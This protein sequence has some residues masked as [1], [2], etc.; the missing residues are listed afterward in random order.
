MTCKIYDALSNT[1][2]ARGEIA[3]AAENAMVL[4]NENNEVQ[5]LLN[6]SKQYKLVTD[7]GTY[8]GLVVPIKASKSYITVKLDGS[9]GSDKRR[10]LRMPCD[11]P[12]RVYAIDGMIDCTV[13]ELAYGSCMINSK[14]ELYTD[15][16]TTIQMKSPS[17][18]LLTLNG[19]IKF[20]KESNNDDGIWFAGYDYMI[21]FEDANNL[22]QALDELY[23][24]LLVMMRNE[25]AA[26]SAASYK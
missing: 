14:E 20:G 6:I 21:S 10:Y 11:I 17:G 2:V 13:T 8:S 19:V 9:A 12:G 26:A 23:G 18:N 7:D 22:E 4:H 16:T 25:R 1:L 24:T 15:E 5:A 3:K